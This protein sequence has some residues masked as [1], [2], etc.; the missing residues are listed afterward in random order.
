MGNPDTVGQPLDI[1]PILEALDMIDKG[2][3][4]FGRACKAVGLKPIQDPFWKNL[5]FINIFQSSTPDILH[6]MYQGNI[7]HLIGWIQTACGEEE[8]DARC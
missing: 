2:L 8:I 5:P 7:K 1:L 3:A 4:A 6:Q